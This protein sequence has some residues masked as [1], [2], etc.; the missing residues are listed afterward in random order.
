MCICMV[1]AQLEAVNNLN[2]L[3]SCPHQTLAQYLALKSHCEPNR[4]HKYSLPGAAACVINFTECCA[5]CVT[6]LGASRGKGSNTS[7]DREKEQRQRQSV[8]VDLW[9]RRKLDRAVGG[10][11]SAFLALLGSRVMFLFSASAV[12]RRA[13]LNAQPPISVDNSRSVCCG[14]GVTRFENVICVSARERRRWG[15]PHPAEIGIMACAHSNIEK[16]AAPDVKGRGLYARL[17]PRIPCV[18]GRVSIRRPLL[19]L[20]ANNGIHWCEMHLTR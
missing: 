16:S 10:N 17:A 4:L 6:P 13:A 15:R 20:Q 8:V 2:E 11:A 9:Q 12:T 1:D 19:N 7:R 3:A 14:G 5:P 18:Q